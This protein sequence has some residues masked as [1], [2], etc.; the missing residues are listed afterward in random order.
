MTCRNCV[1]DRTRFFAYSLHLYP[2]HRTPDKFKCTD[3]EKA[4]NHL[5]HS[6]LV[7]PKNLS[8]TA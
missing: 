1:C 6:Q 2:Y 8:Q 4:S 7:M 5:S 3:R